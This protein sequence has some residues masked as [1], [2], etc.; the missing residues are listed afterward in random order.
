MRTLVGLCDTL[1][2]S[3]LRR[4]PVEMIISSSVESFTNIDLDVTCNVDIKHTL[5]LITLVADCG[6]L[7]LNKKV[8]MEFESLHSCQKWLRWR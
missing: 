8:R 2:S 6:V 3:L 1:F 4:Y 5:F 7:K